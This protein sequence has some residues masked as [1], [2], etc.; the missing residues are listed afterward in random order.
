MNLHS[1]FLDYVERK[2]VKQYV[3]S[4]TDKDLVMRACKGVDCVMHVASIVDTS[5]IPDEEK[6]YRINV[7]GKINFDNKKRKLVDGSFTLLAQY[8]LVPETETKV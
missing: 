2:P 3:G 5:L 8:W 6:S 1:S 4:V 7:K